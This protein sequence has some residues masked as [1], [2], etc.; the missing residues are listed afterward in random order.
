MMKLLYKRQFNEYM[1][2]MWQSSGQAAKAVLLNSLLKQMER[3][4][5]SRA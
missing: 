4:T 3:A 2:A 1:Y 5:Q